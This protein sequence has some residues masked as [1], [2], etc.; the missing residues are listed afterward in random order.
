MCKDFNL[1]LILTATPDPAITELGLCRVRDVITIQQ[2][3]LAYKFCNNL[4][5]SDLCN[6]FTNIAQILKPPTLL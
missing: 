6:L 1:F 3:K 2:L 5:P 4:L